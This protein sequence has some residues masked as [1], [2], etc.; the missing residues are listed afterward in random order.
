MEI[1][2]LVNLETLTKNRIATVALPAIA[3]LGVLFTNYLVFMVVPDEQVMGAVQRIFYFHVGSAMA[4]YSMIGVLFLAS[5]M[6]LN[7][8]KPQWDAVAE[9]AAAVGFTFCTVVLVTGMIW[10]HSAW[11]VWWR[12]E[13]RLVSFLVLWFVMFSYVLLRG[14]T[15]NHPRKRNLA[16][17]LGIISAVNVPI[18][19]FS[20]KLLDNTQQLH[21]EVVAKQGL[22]D[23][24]FVYTLVSA[25]VFL[26]VAAFWFMMVQ[27]RRLL[28]AQSVTDLRRIFH[29]RS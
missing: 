29:S 26:I 23:I 9:S 11:N 20:I 25:N 2:K 12:W 5:V 16:A 19:I 14:F 13:P 8:K 15:E 6:Y 7:S 3:S 1:E 17:A 22:R 18:V 21:P 28:I 10:G 4:C 27:L 24:S